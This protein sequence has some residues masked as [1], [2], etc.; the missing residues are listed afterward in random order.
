MSSRRWFQFR[1]RTFF[2][3]MTL[4]CAVAWWWCGQATWIGKRREFLATPRA[5]FV[6][7]PRPGQTIATAP[8]LLWLFGEQRCTHLLVAVGDEITEAE[9]VDVRR[10]F[11]ETLMTVVDGR[12][13]KYPHERVRRNWKPG[14]PWEPLP[15]SDYP[16]GYRHPR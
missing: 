14:E 2:V 12:P 6:R 11:P 3:L 4:L 13:Q 10:L 1:L 8:G 9:L 16:P 7:A 5:V 15:P